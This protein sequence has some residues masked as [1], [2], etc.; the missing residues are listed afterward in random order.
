MTGV[1][2]LYHARTVGEMLPLDEKPRVQ[3]PTRR[4]TRCRCI[5][6]QYNSD[7]KCAPCDEKTNPL[8]YIEPLVKRKAY[9]TRTESKAIAR[10]HAERYGDVVRALCGYPRGMTFAAREIADITRYSAIS[11]A[12]YF[13]RAESDGLIERAGKTCHRGSHGPVQLWQRRSAL[14]ESA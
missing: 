5:L 2:A 4:C 1:D 13:L 7:T 11:V 10:V 14:M 9:G 8:T 3:M 6:S 12:S